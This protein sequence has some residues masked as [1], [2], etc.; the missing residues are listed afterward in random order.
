MLFSCSC[1][2]TL[3]WSFCIS[4]GKYYALALLNL[5]WFKSLNSIIPLGCIPYTISNGIFLVLL[6]TELL[7]ANSACTRIWS[8][9]WPCSVT[10][11]LNKFPKLL[12]TNSVYPSIWGWYA[13]LKDNFIPSLFH[14]FLQ[15]C[16]TNL[17]SLSETMLL[18]NPCTLITSLKNK[19]AICVASFVF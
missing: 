16:P 15:K 11:L 4:V 12:F 9:W 19:L 7:N 17:V 6:F 3:S 10:K 8:H 2:L 5:S 14:R 13:E 1:S 18:V